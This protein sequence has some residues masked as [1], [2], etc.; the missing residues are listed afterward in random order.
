MGEIYAEK[1]R[2]ALTRREPAI[3]DFFDLYHAI[4]KKGLNTHDP[5]FIN[6]VRTKIL[7]PG[8]DSVDISTEKKLELDWQ[9]KGQLRPVLR[10]RNFAWFNLDEIFDLVLSMAEAISG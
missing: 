4:K 9:L 7:L 8:N 3:R 1:F 5:E 10:P 2:A 6:M